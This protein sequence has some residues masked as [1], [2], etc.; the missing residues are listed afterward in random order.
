[1][2]QNFCDLLDNFPM[3]MRILSGDGDVVYAN[4]SMLDM[5]GVGSLKELVKLSAKDLYT[6]EGYVD[7]L[8]RMAKRSLGESFPAKYETSIVR[9]GETR[10][11]EVFL[12]EVV[13][14]GAVRLQELYQ[15]VTERKRAE[16][17]L[18]RRLE[19]E[20]LTSAVSRRFV[21]AADVN[22]AINESLADLGRICQASR[23]YVFLFRPG[24]AIVD[25]THE[26]CAPGVSPQIGNLQNL[27]SDMFPW[28]MAKLRRG[29]AIHI[30]D[31]SRLPEDAAAEKQI[32][33]S[34][35]IKSLI[36]LPLWVKGDLAGFI[37]FDNVVLT[38]HWRPEDMSVLKTAV[39]IFAG[40]LWRQRL[41][42]AVR[43]AGEHRYRR[44]MESAHDAILVVE[45]ETE[46]I[47]D[48]NQKACELVALPREK[49]VGLHQTRIFPPE[50]AE[51]RTRSFLQTITLGGR[52]TRDVVVLSADGRR[53][54]TDIGSSLWEIEGKKFLTGVFR[55][56]TEHK[57][58]E[59]ALRTEHSTLEAI[60]AGVGEGLVVADNLK[61]VVYYNHAAEEILGLPAA[62]VVG[63]PADALYDRLA[64]RV[65]E[66]RDWRERVAGHFQEAAGR[67]RVHYVFKMPERRDVEAGFFTIRSRGER[68]GTGAV[69]HDITREKE[70]DRIKTE[71]ISI[72][73]HELRTPM[74]GIYGFAELLLKSNSLSG[75][76]REYARWIHR[77][78]ERMNRI[79]EDIL[80]VSRME[81]GRFPF[82]IGPVA[83][84]PL[85]TGTLNTITARYP[86]HSFT[87]TV[88]NEL[89][90]V[91]AD[92]ERL[93]E[94]LHNL[95]ENAVKYSREGSAV[96]ITAGADDRKQEV[97]LAVSD[98]GYGIPEDDIP[99][100]F[101]RFY[102]VRRAEET[103]RGTGLG[104][105]I[106]KSLVEMM[107]GRVWVES[108]VNQGSTFF[109]SLPRRP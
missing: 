73:S 3:G 62:E 61:T 68:L 38:G 11:L 66:P 45:V 58:A 101:E 64:S 2:E 34:Q 18:G 44:L 37:G 16:T 103:V 23:S 46:T 104:L 27:P 21:A 78:S 30:D 39:E 43:E 36:V 99:H 10:R 47:V 49:I 107:N 67:S 90:E 5:F 89:P 57:K 80:N 50:D 88:G 53:I 51:S 65:A 1:M 31:V 100:L 93:T 35:D 94:V 82:D 15:D 4:R 20:K 63:R 40:A 17:S 19:F 12:S 96:T 87:V 79:I 24:G 8:Q 28:W 59:E 70:A 13:W 48:C 26:W 102:R 22:A 77:E 32:L 84:G 85:I 76:D 108:R 97:V 95:V 60:I 56:M 81:T 7:H 109:L 29:E 54:W 75:D 98:Q 55:D 71:F 6:P 25:N 42:R 69:F 91:L 86:T 74:T 41:E 14:E 33:E 9:K 92:P 105:Y 72:A 83:V 52:L 106:V